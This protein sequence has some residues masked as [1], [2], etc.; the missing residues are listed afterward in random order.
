MAAQPVVGRSWC[1]VHPWRTI[2][3]FFR[4][5]VRLSRL[6]QYRDWC[7]APCR[8]EEFVVDTRPNRGV[9]KGVSRI[10]GCQSTMSIGAYLRSTKH[11]IEDD[12]KPPP[13]WNSSNSNSSSNSSRINSSNREERDHDKGSGIRTGAGMHHPGLWS[14]ADRS[15][16]AAG[17]MVGAT[18]LA[19]DRV[20]HHHQE[21][22]DSQLPLISSIIGHGGLARVQCAC[23]CYCSGSCFGSHRRDQRSHPHYHHRRRL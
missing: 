13:P 19:S 2:L 7:R 23:F 6:T 8:V 14:L 11:T 20:Q 5:F 10:H 12:D 3:S 15:S 22:R 9:T 17:F 21:Q 18:A 1:A 16:E 4:F